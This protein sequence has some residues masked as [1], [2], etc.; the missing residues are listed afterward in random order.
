MANKKKDTLCLHCNDKVTERQYSVACSICDRWIHKDCGI[1]DD[2]YKLIDKIHQRKGFHSWSCDGCSLGLTKLHKMIASNQRDIATL[3]IDVDSVTATTSINTEKI[4]SNKKDIDSMKMDIDS[5]KNQPTSS[6]S[7]EVLAELD[8]RESKRP[9]LMIFS[10]SEPVSTL[11]N[12]E[13]KEIDI[14]K[15]EDICSSIGCSID[16]TPDIKFIYRVGEQ[17]TKPRPLS[18]GFRNPEIKEKI[19][20]SAWKLGKNEGLKHISLAPD[21]TLNQIEK[22]KELLA[23]ASSRNKSLTDADAKNFVWKLIGPRG[24]R[25]LRKVK[26]RE[27]ENQN[28]AQ[29]RPRIRSLRRTRAE[30]EDQEDQEGEKS[31]EVTHRSKKQC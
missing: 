30:M 26:K 6:S 7:A 31:A 5:L 20:K 17:G 25:I 12:S 24:N 15:V 11:P 18:V 28:P 4:D 22:E 16:P 21:L 1:D 10:L 13:K 27:E 14:E 2:E 9:N 3:R 23:D 19:L 8:L 29:P